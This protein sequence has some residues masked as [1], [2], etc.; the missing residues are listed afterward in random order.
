MELQD[1]FHEHPKAALGFSGGVD[2]SYL[3]W[4]ARQC[5]ADVR[6]YYI[7]TA[8]QPEF[9]F[10]DAK[11]LCREIGAELTVLELD[12]LSDPAVAA[13]PADRCYHCKRNLF[14]T[15][16]ARALADGYTLL[17][18]GTNA[19]DDAGDRPGMRALR[20]L[21]VR[22][23]LRECGLTKARI[24]ALSRE[25]GLFTWDKP[26]YAC[27]A[28]RVPT[29]ETITA[30]KLQKTERA[31]ALLFSLGF[32]DFRVRYFAGAARIQ[33]PEA[34]LP[35]TLTSY[36]P[37]FRKEVG[38]HGLEERGVYRIHQF[39]KQ[40]MIVVCRPEESMIWYD[41][42]WRNSVELF[43]NMEIPVRQLECCSGDLADL[44]VKSCDIE[45]W[46][47][48]QQK[49]FEVCSCSN[50]GDAQARRLGIR[51]K[52]ADGK[53]YLAHTLNNTCVAPPRMLI[54]FLEN[55]LQKD[56]TVTIPKCLQPYM[57]GKEVLIPKHK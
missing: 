29:G 15:L 46:S 7:K 37:C 14:G 41:K 51:V 20:E 23:P 39:E 33:L 42:L 48:R 17:L 12:A 18:D 3:L 28:T 22:S 24:R 49:Y 1:F 11:R 45:A 31:E 35:L 43:R 34:Q 8:F 55:H 21:S 32:R 52:G 16:A 27:L 4:A 47:P 38:S 26:A 53:T 57:G 56:G 54:A 10:E 9:E 36:S 13:N 50:L 19:S 2:S 40:E 5:G 30:E 25:A 6:P 44:K